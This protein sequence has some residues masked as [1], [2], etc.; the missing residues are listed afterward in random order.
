MTSK[1]REERE[2]QRRELANKRMREKVAAARRRGIC[3]CGG[4]LDKKP[5][6]RRNYSTCPDC[7]EKA[8]RYYL[9]GPKRPKVKPPAK[10][11]GRLRARP[12]SSGAFD[13]ITMNC[14]LARRPVAGTAAAGIVG[15]RRPTPGRGAGLG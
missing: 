4:K 6:A 3:R 13:D 9:E 15:R 12:G 2:K 10:L 8:A 11:D 5:G 7:R 1:E 14:D